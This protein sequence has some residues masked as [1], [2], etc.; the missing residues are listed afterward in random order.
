VGEPE[1]GRGR[2]RGRGRECKGTRVELHLCQPHHNNASPVLL[3]QHTQRAAY[4][5]RARAHPPT[6]CAHALHCTGS[7]VRTGAHSIAGGL[8]AC[9][10]RGA[11]EAQRADN[12]PRPP[13][14]V[15]KDGDGGSSETR[16]VPS[17][18]TRGEAGLNATAWWRRPATPSPPP[19]AH[20]GTTGAR[21]AGATAC[22]AAAGAR[23]S[24]AAL[25]LLLL[26]LVA[27]ATGR[28]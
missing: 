2:G 14:A 1:R 3:L 24:G 6:S 25:L 16:R 21:R 17:T 8:C 23:A 27:L 7:T 20:P 26:L 13:V 19:Q 11:A 5:A 10:G 18:S 15:K 4:S 28:P 9:R 22:A 12:K